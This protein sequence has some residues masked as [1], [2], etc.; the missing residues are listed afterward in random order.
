MT[1]E[2]KPADAEQDSEFTTREM[3]AEGRRNRERWQRDRE[4]IRASYPNHWIAIY[5]SGETVAAHE[6][7]QAHFDHIFQLEGLNRSSV[8]TWPPPRE[9]NTRLVPSVFRTRKP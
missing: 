5:D 9:P 2:S 6:Q 7:A 4:Q 8:L 1:T 3:F